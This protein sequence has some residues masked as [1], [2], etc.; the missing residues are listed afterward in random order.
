M[1]KETAIF[2]PYD[3]NGRCNLKCTGKGVYIIFHQDHDGKRPVYVG[4]SLGD[5][6]NTLYRHFQKWTDKRHPD[7]KKV[8]IY[9]RVTYKNSKG[10]FKSDKYFI[11]VIFTNSDNQA[12]AL[13]YL[14]IKKYQPEDNTNKQLAFSLFNIDQ[15]KEIYSKREKTPHNTEKDPF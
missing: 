6:K 7:N 12:N 13:E 11:R 2:K 9:E 10:K 3:D 5:L 14:L 8:E 1:Y 4:K 15:I